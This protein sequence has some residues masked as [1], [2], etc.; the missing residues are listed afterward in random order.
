MD[1][2][3]DN[4]DPPLPFRNLPFNGFANHYTVGCEMEEEGLTSHILFV[5]TSDDG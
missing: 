4:G 1:N 3:K 5:E 2:T